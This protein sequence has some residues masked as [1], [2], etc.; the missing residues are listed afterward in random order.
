MSTNVRLKMLT[1]RDRFYK[2][3]I[4]GEIAYEID[5]NGWESD[6][7]P[8]GCAKYNDEA[9]QDIAFYDGFCEDFYC[10]RIKEK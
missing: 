7:G 8:K 1:N 10:F 6:Q 2:D 9:H 5:S 3:A 4:K